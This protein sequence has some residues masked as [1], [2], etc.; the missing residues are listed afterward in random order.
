MTWWFPAPVETA[1]PVLAPARRWR[2]TAVVLVA[3]MFLWTF[4]LKPMD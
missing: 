4:V 1:G 2:R 3:H